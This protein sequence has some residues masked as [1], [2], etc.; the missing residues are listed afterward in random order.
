MAEPRQRRR[1]RPGLVFAG[2]I[3]IHA[4]IFLGVAR[5]RAPPFLAA[6]DGAAVATPVSFAPRPAAIRR[7]PAPRK[8]RRAS[9]RRPS[10]E[11]APIAEVKTAAGPQVRLARAL[12]PAS[13]LA[14]AGL[15]DASLIAPGDAGA[16]ADAGGGSDHYPINPGYWEVVLHWLLIDR[17]ERYCVEP[18]NIARF[19]AVP[20]N[21]IY[22][23]SEPTEVFDGDTFSFQ[24]VVSGSHERFD[25]RGHGAYAPERLHVSARIQGHYKIL[26]VVILGSLDGRFLGADCPADA[27]RIR[28]R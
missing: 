16:R 2:S 25:V 8:R 20:C 7:D 14:A 10:A 21:H 3:I 15:P 24:E 28:Q 12:G 6:S 13:P 9:P 1:R 26:P 18:R 11:I 22:H 19:M 23:C 27:K 5:D 4:C 17:T